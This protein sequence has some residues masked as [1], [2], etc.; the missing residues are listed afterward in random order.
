MDRPAGR[1]LIVDDDRHLREQIAWSLKS[2]HTVSEAGDRTSGLAALRNAPPDLV[3]LDLHMPP[4]RGVREGMHLLEEIRNAGLDTL[5]IVMTGD[6]AKESALHAIE[7]GAYDFFR[8]PVELAELKLIIRRALEKQ[9]IERENRRLKEQLRQRTPFDE[10]LGH[11][12]AMRRVFEAIRRVAGGDTTVILRGESGTGKELVA[13]A[14]HGASDRKDGPFVAVQ[15]SALPE[16]LIESELFGHEK[17]AFTGA[18]AARQGRF[19]MAH[20]GTLFLDEIGTLSPMVQAKLLRVLEGKQFERVGGK[21]MVHV[22]VRLISATNEDLED[23]IRQGG[24]REDLY[25]RI[26]VFPIVLP[27][28]RERREDIPLL[29]DHYLRCFCQARGTPPKSIAPDAL[30]QLQ[31]HAWK[32][33]VRELVNV[34]QNL[35]LT[36]DGSRIVAADLPKQLAALPFEAAPEAVKLDG[37]PIDLPAAVVRFEQQLME[38]ALARA[39][40]VKAEAARLLGIDKNQMMYLCR[41]H[42]L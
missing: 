28:L 40:G 15:C 2:E 21:Q 36:T 20:G 33:N 11:S 12:E 27:P 30:E 42:R 10:I 5:V 18:I 1:I 4:G 17:G 14:I 25:Y 6:E 13:R 37:H 35:V 22:D 39:G 24:F 7:A 41:K 31:R 26:N 9:R 16:G 38:Q 23:R 34:V 32:G 19:E 3:L 29:V 8:K